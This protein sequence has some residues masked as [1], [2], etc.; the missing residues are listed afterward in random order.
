MT[1][2]Q[3]ATKIVESEKFSI[4][5]FCYADSA[6]AMR[7]EKMTKEQL[8]KYLSRYDHETLE[9]TLAEL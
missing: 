9:T 7:M 8:I 6:R 4:A 1:K 3:M 2:L 5:D